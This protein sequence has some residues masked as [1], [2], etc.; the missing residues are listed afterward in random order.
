MLNVELVTP[1]CLEFSLEASLVEIPGAEGDFSVLIGHAPMIS[2]LRPGVITLH[3][4]NNLEKCLFV[5]SGFVEVTAERCTILAEEAID[6]EGMTLG[7]AEQRLLGAKE[8][9]KNLPFGEDEQASR[10]AIEVAKLL[11]ESFKTSK[12]VH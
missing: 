7:K 9:L 8:A 12:A 11:I 2:T 3:S 4:D 10:R 1:E 6:L 5:A